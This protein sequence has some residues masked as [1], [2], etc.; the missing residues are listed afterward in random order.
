M[1]VINIIQVIVSVLLII[2]VLLQAKGG[3]L[4]A[5]FGGSETGFQTRRGAEKTIFIGTIV[6]TV[7]FLGLG[8]VNIILN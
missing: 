2:A 1:S 7:F 6:L 3:G 5:T 8:I 4:S